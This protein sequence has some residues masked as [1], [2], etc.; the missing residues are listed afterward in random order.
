MVAAAIVAAVVVA[1]KTGQKEPCTPNHANKE[2]WEARPP[3]VPGP[4]ETLAPQNRSKRTLGGTV[5]FA[6]P[7]NLPGPFE[8]LSRNGTQSRAK[9][10]CAPNHVNK[11]PWEARPP[12]VPGAFETLTPQSRSKKDLGRH[13][14]QI[15]QV[16]L[17]PRNSAQNSEKKK[18]TQKLQLRHSF[19]QLPPRPTPLQKPMKHQTAFPHAILKSQSLLTFLSTLPKT[20]SKTYPRKNPVLSPKKIVGAPSLKAPFNSL[21]SLTPDKNQSLTT[22]LHHA[23]SRTTG[24]PLGSLPFTRSLCVPTGVGG[25]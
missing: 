15:Y 17:K 7:P 6:L 22:A 19:P 25:C 3:N 8:T 18:Q 2:P 24:A 13:C 23:F 12:N 9:K 14:P 10:T 21:G 5:H 20:I 11:E 1:P 4:L 16:R